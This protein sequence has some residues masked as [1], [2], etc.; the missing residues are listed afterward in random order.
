MGIDLVCR[1]QLFRSL[2]SS[3]TATC[4]QNPTSSAQH[5]GGPRCS[6]A[7]PRHRG[8]DLGLGWLRLFRGVSGQITRRCA[9][10]LLAMG[11]TGDAGTVVLCFTFWDTR[12][13]LDG[14]LFL[15]AVV[16][17]YITFRFT[18]VFLLIARCILL[19]QRRRTWGLAWTQ[20]QLP[21]GQ[22]TVEFTIK[23]LRQQTRQD[24]PA[25]IDRRESTGA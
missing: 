20:W 15:Q 16:V 1:R 12:V 2:Q 9:S 23:F 14:M 18:A 4:Q 5:R 25:V 19:S 13:S 11:S 24:T 6:A 3:P 8:P 17:S 22:L 10:S 21:A 7:S